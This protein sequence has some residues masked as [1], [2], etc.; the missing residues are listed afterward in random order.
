MN[1][2]TF[3]TDQ[4]CP[5]WIKE[6]FRFLP[7]KSQ[8]VLSGNIRDR[9]PFPLAVGEETRYMPYTL[10][11][12]LTEMLGMRGY[13]RFLSYDIFGVSTGRSGWK[14]PSRPAK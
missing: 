13:T 5:R 12:S 6:V 4:L 1:E 11:Q 7:V 10:P 9:Y 14:P 2:E 3:S 8:F